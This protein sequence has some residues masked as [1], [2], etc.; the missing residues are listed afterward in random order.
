MLGMGLMLFCLRAMAPAAAWKEWLLRFAFWAIN[1]GLFAMVTFSLLPVG[2]M[3][4][5]ASVERGYWYA[6][7]AEFL[8]TPVMEALRWMRVPGD[9]I[10]AF[11]AIALV[12][13][14]FRSTL[15]PLPETGAMEEDGALPAP[16]RGTAPARP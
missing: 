7:S 8:Q 5:W 13:F 12:V 9:T 2:L 3:Q 11:G 15:R 1:F 16:K 6:R 14:V 10:F 4:T